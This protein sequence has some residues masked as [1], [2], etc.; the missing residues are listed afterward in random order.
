[1]LKSLEGVIADWESIKEAKTHPS[2]E[3]A[4][5]SLD[6]AVIA[7]SFEFLLVLN[8]IKATRRVIQ[9]ACK[10][11]GLV[12][13]LLTDSRWTVEEKALVLLGLEPLT[14]NGEGDGNEDK[15]EAMVLPDKGTGIKKQTLKALLS[16]TTSRISAAQTL[17]RDFHRII[18]QNVDVRFPSAQWL[19]FL[20]R[21]FAGPGAIQYSDHHSQ[22]CSP[23]GD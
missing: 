1:M 5:R 7:L 13:P 12:T 6:T 16:D 11:V 19:Q 10:L 14:C 17:R 4:R 15:W 21:C 8:G 3:K 9:C 22:R 18:W 2:A 20:I 23:N